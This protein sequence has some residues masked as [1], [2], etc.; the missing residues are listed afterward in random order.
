MKIFFDTN[1]YVAEALL[2]PGAQRIVRATIGASWRIYASSYVA[3]EAQRVIS[4]KLGYARR[5]A[6]QTRL[7]ILRRAAKVETPASRHVVKQD[8]ADNPVLQ[9][10]VAAGVGRGLSGHERCASAGD[11][12]L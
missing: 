1:V 10:A 5:F 11:G 6:L 9:A 2:G 4:E 12:S 8:A 7:R 3:A